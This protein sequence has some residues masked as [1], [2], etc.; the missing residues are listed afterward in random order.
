MVTSP[1]PP[2]LNVRLLPA[3]PR[4]RAST[5]LQ[6]MAFPGPNSAFK[7]FRAPLPPVFLVTQA[8]GNGHI[9]TVSWGIWFL[10]RSSSWGQALLVLDDS[11]PPPHLPNLVLAFRCT[12]FP[13]H[14][15]VCQKGGDT[16][17]ATGTS[18]LM[19]QWPHIHLGTPV[20]PGPNCRAV[21]RSPP[22]WVL[23]V[24]RHHCPSRHAW[25]LDPLPPAALPKTASHCR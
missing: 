12:A 19:V 8:P 5:Q 10:H 15:S 20:T 3:G 14:P 18:V 24:P 23:Q 4:L 17:K 1:Q 22:S 9:S 2:D 25:L 16:Y 7:A 6:M 11:S 13:L 21:K